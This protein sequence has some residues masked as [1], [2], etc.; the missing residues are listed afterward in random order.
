MLLTMIQKIKEMIKESEA[1]SR[2][3][4]PELQK[5]PNAWS[6]GYE[7]GRISA[8]NDVLELIRIE[9]SCLSSLYTA[10]MELRTCEVCAKMNEEALAK[11]DAEYKGPLRL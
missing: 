8:L 4:D 11:F 2:E 3:I 1:D 9:N 7:T 6:G 5:N 10:V